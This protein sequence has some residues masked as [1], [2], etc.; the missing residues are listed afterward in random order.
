MKKYI[1]L[2][3][4]AFAGI[5]SSCEDVIDVD[6]KEEDLNLIAVEAS[7]TTEDEPTV[8]LY[9]TLKVSQDEEYTG[10]SDAV[11][12]LADD[13]SPSNQIV[14]TEDALRKGFYTVPQGASYKGVAGREYTLTIQTP[15]ATLTA[16]DKLNPV[17]PID[18]VIIEPSVRGDSLFLAVFT[19]GLEPK[20]VGNYYKWDVYVNDTLENKSYYM[21]IASDEFVDGNYV[22]KLEI[23][24][25]FH[26]PD[27]PEERELKLNDRVYVKQ[28]SI[29]QFAYNFYLQMI[30]QANSGGLFSV[31]PANIKGN[32][33]STDGK[34]VL[35]LFIARDVSLSNT[36]VIDQSIEDQLKKP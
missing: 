35:G 8:F 7:I 5:M 4:V 6:L 21:A 16:K 3:L 23:F 22:N 31:P 33:T 9:R 2:I 25:D 15:E 20:G 24:T 1:T 11:V 17:E 12:V 27:K 36:V 13:A 29:S 30:N 10:L 18:S 28:T 14:L 34:Q 32:F 26:D 19:Y